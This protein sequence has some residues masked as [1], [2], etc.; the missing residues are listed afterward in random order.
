MRLVLRIKTNGPQEKKV[1][2]FENFPPLIQLAVQ[3]NTMFLFSLHVFIAY[4]IRPIG[5]IYTS[6]CMYSLVSIY[7]HSWYYG[8]IMTNT[9]MPTV[10][11]KR[12][13]SECNVLKTLI[14]SWNINLYLLHTRVIIIYLLE[15]FY[16]H[17]FV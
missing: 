4:D 3:I 11:C 17:S 5:N 12:I 14:V 9:S 15:A 7:L 13:S 1:F 8:P 6:V 16:G 2:F 10:V